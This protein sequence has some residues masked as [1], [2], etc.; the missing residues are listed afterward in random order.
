MF[1]YIG[2]NFLSGYGG[3]GINIS[4]AFSSANRVLIEQGVAKNWYTV[5][6]DPRTSNGK[7]VTLTFEVNRDGAPINPRIT[8]SEFRAMRRAADREAREAAGQ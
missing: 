1:S 5:P 6:I 4:P 3:Y 7:R 8:V 2:S